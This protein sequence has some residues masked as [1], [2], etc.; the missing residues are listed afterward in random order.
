[1]P[2]RQ[3]RNFGKSIALSNVFRDTP[4]QV[5]DDLREP[6]LNVLLT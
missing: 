5:I 4:E 6:F 1:M 2:P 3:L